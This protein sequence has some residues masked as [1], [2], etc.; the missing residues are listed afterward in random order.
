MTKFP[1]L[2]VDTTVAL[3]IVVGGFL[4]EAFDLFTVALVEDFD[5][6]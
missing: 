5:F 3:A 2:A 4:D 1:S 6:D